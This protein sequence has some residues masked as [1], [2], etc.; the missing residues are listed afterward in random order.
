MNSYTDDKDVVISV[1]DKREYEILSIALEDYYKKIQ[2]TVEDFEKHMENLDRGIA[3]RGAIGAALNEA[4]TERA[5]VEHM[6]RVV[7]E[8]KAHFNDRNEL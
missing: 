1:D 6:I 3:L 5:T 4:V 7:N 2:A 8:K